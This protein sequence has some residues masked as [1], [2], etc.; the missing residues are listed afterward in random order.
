MTSGTG[1]RKSHAK[2]CSHVFVLIAGAV[3]LISGAGKLWSAFGEM[4][5]LDVA[6]PILA[7]QFRYLMLA[8]GVAELVIAFVCL[9][10]QKTQL[11]TLCVAWLG[12]GFLMYQLG[13]WWMDWERP[14]HC[15]GNFA[16]ALHI[17]PQLADNIMKVVLAYLLIGSYGLLTR[18]WMQRRH[19]VGVVSAGQ[20]D[21]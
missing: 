2:S 17:S 20:A 10:T 15:L 13:L 12:T 3:L 4:K 5:L 16:E 1:H 7:I 14:C 8:A 18:E 9:F 21:G 11:A 19:S 6:D